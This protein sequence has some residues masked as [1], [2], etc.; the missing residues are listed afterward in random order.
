MIAINGA[1]EKKAI[2]NIVIDIIS[3]VYENIYDMAVLNSGD[4]E[5]IPIVKKIKELGKN[6]EVWGLDIR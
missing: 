4:G 3:L 2:I 5:F 1:I 6:V